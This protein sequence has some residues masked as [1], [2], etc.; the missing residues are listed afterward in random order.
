MTLNNLSPQIQLSVH[1]LDL[2]FVQ[3]VVD[4]HPQNQ[5]FCAEAPGLRRSHLANVSTKSMINAKV[6]L[7]HS[8]DQSV[9]VRSPK[10]K[11][12]ETPSTPTLTW[13]NP[14]TSP[15]D[16]IITQDDVPVPLSTD[17]Q[18]QYPPGGSTHPSYSWPNPDPRLTFHAHFVPLIDNL[19]DTAQVPKLSLPI[20][21]RQVS[22]SGLLPVVFDPY[23]QAFKLTPMGPM[24]LPSEELHQG[25]LYR[26]TPGGDMHPETDM[27]PDMSLFSDGSD[28]DVY[29]FEG[30]DCTLPQCNFQGSTFLEGKFA[31]EPC[32][33]GSAFSQEPLSGLS[34]Y[35]EACDCP[36]DIID[37]EDGWR[38][39][40][41]KERD[42][43]SLFN[44]SPGKTWLKSGVAMS[45]RK[46][47]QPIPSLIVQAMAVTEEGKTP[48]LGKQNKREF[49]P[50]KSVVTPV[51]VDITL[52]GD[53][54]FTLMEFLCYF[55]LHF[56]WS[57]GA[58]R[59]SS[60]DATKSEI[61]YLINMTRGLSDTEGL[62]KGTV[63][64][65]V[66][67][68]NKTDAAADPD[69]TASSASLPP[70][71]SAASWTHDALDKTDYPLLGLA[72]GLRSLP[73]GPDA[74]PL[75]ALIVQ[76]RANGRYQTM[77]SEVPR[78]L[79]EAGIEGVI[80]VGNGE[81]D[82]EV[83]PRHAEAIAEFRRRMKAEV[84]MESG[85]DRGRK[86][87]KVE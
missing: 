35:D 31:V 73:S 13:A 59:L 6:F 84:G 68:K 30:V 11:E 24:P 86:R 3:T 20:G 39:M 21:W 10:K 45:K 28:A 57:N 25:G 38:W 61:T 77:L 83:M 2:G 46:W 58:E 56:I 22:W 1:P 15:Y 17:W 65:H 66:F 53:V 18:L 29:N 78:L 27:L 9:Q 67:F 75:T 70:P 62:T 16:V 52:L 54:E 37:L 85:E 79:E 76:C 12:E 7:T 47:K 4:T 41:Q 80:D 49:C 43:R 14:S 81:P 26:Y 34:H 23:H 51:S 8:I 36:D 82:R 64:R 5:S 72:H 32:E 69:Q 19:P 48:F 50:I 74:G 44:K 33:T 71:Y 63:Y 42:P 60:A 87:K 55:P 40:M